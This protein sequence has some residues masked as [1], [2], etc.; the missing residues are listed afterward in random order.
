MES[1]PD[2]SVTKPFDYQR[3]ALVSDAASGQLLGIVGEFKASVRQKLKLPVN[4][5]GFE[6]SLET[7]MEG[8]SANRYK[9]VPRFPKVNQDI[10]LRL[11]DGISYGDLVTVLKSGLDAAKP[12]NSLAS[13]Q[14]LSIYKKT[15]EDAISKRKLMFL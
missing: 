4:T 14:P 13:L 1:E 2:Y 5:A 3:S 9:P 8:A 12:P 7:L 10:T 11:P 15:G 6:I